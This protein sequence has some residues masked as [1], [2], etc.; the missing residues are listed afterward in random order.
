[1]DPATRALMMGAAGS[2]AAAIEFIASA[3]F[4]TTSRT[5]TLAIGKPAGTQQGDL[6][7]AFMA[8]NGNCTW[9]GDSGWTEVIDQGA[10]PSLRVA[11]LVA[12][13]SEPSSYTFT[14]SK[15]ES[16]SSGVIATF[17]NAA[18]DVVGTISTTSPSNVQTAP[19]ITLSTGNSAIL[20]FFASMSAGRTWSN[21]TSGLISTATD[22]D[23]E[24]PS[25]ALYRELDLPS[26]STGTRS[27]TASGSLSSPACALI[28]IK[29]S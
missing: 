4:Q 15:D 11:Y 25:L 3:Q 19:S 26:G 6:M 28:G 12:G 13:A 22:S 1:M 18:Y 17:R 21:A 24:P 8:V 10:T 27:A 23:V 9:T 16:K 7:V 14:F 29:P 20:A 5:T 2:G